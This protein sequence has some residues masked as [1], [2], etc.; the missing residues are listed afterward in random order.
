MFE[1]QEVARFTNWSNHDFTW[2]W[3]GEEATFEAGESRIMPIGLAEHFA[4]HLTNRE[5]TRVGLDMFCS[6]KTAV[7]VKQFKEFFD[8]AFTTE[9]EKKPETLKEKI[10]VEEK[11][12]EEQIANPI[13]RGR[14]R[15]L[16]D[17]DTFEGK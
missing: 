5:L 4:K 10:E 15:K 1:S 12:I 11:R 9:I 3:A 13:K 2:K 6:P 8:K 16:K 17:E 7:E 14:R